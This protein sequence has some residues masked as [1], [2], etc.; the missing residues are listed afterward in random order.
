[1]PVA[2][3]VNSPSNL[4]TQ[5][6]SGQDQGTLFGI[7]GLLT[8]GLTDKI[9]FLGGQ[10]GTGGPIAQPTPTGYATMQTAGSTTALYTNTAT[11]GGV[12]STQYTFGDL[13]AVLKQF[14]LL[15]A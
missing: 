10:A 2:T 5:L 11:T 1:M 13:V 15:K 9:G 7:G 6:S 8:S 12:G 3:A 4:P 14:G